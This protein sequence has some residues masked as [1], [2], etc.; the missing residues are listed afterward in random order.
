MSDQSPL[1]PDQVRLVRETWRQ[2]V[3]IADTAAAMFYDRLLADNPQLAPLFESSDMPA[4]RQKL[5]Q[6]I[7]MVVV[8]LDKLDSLQP[9]IR[10][11]GRRHVDY[12][13]EEAHY[14]QVGAALLA[15]L[16]KGL[17]HAWSEDAETAW[18]SA[19]RVLAGEMIDAANEAT[20]SA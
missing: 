18:A 15:T 6:A 17:G 8:S 11:L 10:D 12:G 20:A 4:Q 5:V 7:N 16:E 2:V 1:T 13:V 19:Y 9:A 3:P 14:G